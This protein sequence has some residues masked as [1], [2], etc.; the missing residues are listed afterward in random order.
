MGEQKEGM[1][2]SKAL[3]GKR[4]L[5][6]VLRIEALHEQIED[7]YAEVRSYEGQN[8]DSVIRDA[9]EARAAQRSSA[10]DAQAL[11][12]SFDFDEDGN[13]VMPKDE[14]VWP[15]I[16]A[17]MREAVGGDKR[18][19]A[20]VTQIDKLHRLSI[21]SGFPIITKADFEAELARQEQSV[22]AHAD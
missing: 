6:F 13:R 5:E 1:A 15:E 19:M 9:V 2:M 21:A 10:E 3:T 22:G 4:A 16:S 14:L 11:I 12:W 20:M 7:V 17:K 18:L 8:N